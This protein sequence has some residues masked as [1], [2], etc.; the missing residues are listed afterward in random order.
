MTQPTTAPTHSSM[1]QALEALATQSSDASSSLDRSRSTKRKGTNIPTRP[2]SE[3]LKKVKL[4]ETD[5]EEY[6]RNFLILS[7]FGMTAEQHKKLEGA[8]NSRAII[9]KQRMY[10]KRYA[11]IHAKMPNIRSMSK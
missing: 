9:E 10:I 6:E 1:Q 7:Q 11:E 4:D 8:L 5:K 3:S 2:R